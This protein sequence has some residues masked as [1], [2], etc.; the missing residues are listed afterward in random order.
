VAR[1]QSSGGEQRACGGGGGTC[2]RAGLLWPVVFQSPL[3]VHDSIDAL[4]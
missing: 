4:T 2:H 3:S 1:G